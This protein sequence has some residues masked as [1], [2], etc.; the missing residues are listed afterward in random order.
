MTPWLL[1]L[2]CLLLIVRAVIS[3]DG[4]WW[5]GVAVA[6]ALIGLASNRILFASGGLHLLAN[7]APAAFLLL[8]GI[9]SRDGAVLR[10]LSILIGA[11]GFLPFVLLAGAMSLWA[12]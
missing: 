9:R 3:S 2:A 4:W 1:S 10:S 5:R 8:W 11:A 6:L 12:R 7:L